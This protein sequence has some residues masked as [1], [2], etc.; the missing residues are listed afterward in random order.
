MYPLRLRITVLTLWFIAAAVSGHNI[1]DILSDFPEYSVFN[2]YLTQTRLD[3]EINRRETITVLVL[4]NSVMTKFVANQALSVVKP[5]LSIHVLLDYFDMAKLLTIGG[6]SMIS[7]TLYQTTG[8]AA[9]STGFVN[10]TDLKG[11]KIEFGSAD[12]ESK[13]ESLY[14]KSV[15]EFP[16]NISVLEINSPIINLEILPKPLDVNFST[17]LDAARCRTFLKL[18]KSTGVL[19]IYKKVAEQ[20]LTVF[21]PTDLAFKYTGAPDLNNLTNAELVSLLLYHAI[22]SYVP[23]ITL[24]NEK[25]P[26]PTLAT[27]NAGKF[28]FTIQTYGNSLMLNSG[29][30]DSRVLKMVSDAVPVCIFMIDKVLL[31]MELFAKRRVPAA[32][33][34]PAPESSPPSVS[35]TAP[36]SSSTPIAPSPAHIAGTQPVIPPPAPTIP[37]ASSP[38]GGAPP[39]DNPTADMGSNNVSGGDKRKVPAIFLVLVIVSISGIFF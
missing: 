18:L 33:S 35:A 34:S 37:P 11:G 26:M 22:P 8:N 38:V 23:E 13:I 27:N 6:G 16:Y 21:A 15:K 12:K 10:I 25:D 5:A 20:A 39:A 1:T 30:D 4:N 32:A 28:A 14:T 19:D 31:P 24:E 3:D 29:V 17:L 9:G 2:D 36:G 7:T